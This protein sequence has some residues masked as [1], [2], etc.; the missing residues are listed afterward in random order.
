[1]CCG[2][3]SGTLEAERPGARFLGQEDVLVGRGVLPE[4]VEGTLER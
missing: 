3:G 4:A 1:M 2:E